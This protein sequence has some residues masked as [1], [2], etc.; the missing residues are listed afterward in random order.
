MKDETI[1][2]NHIL[3]PEHDLLGDRQK[4]EVLKKYNVTEGQLPKIR[5]NDPAIAGLGA[6]KGDIIRI[7]RKT[8]TAGTSTFYRVVTDV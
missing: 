4:Q 6:K 1:A 7:M 8:R 2:K 3:V 5:T